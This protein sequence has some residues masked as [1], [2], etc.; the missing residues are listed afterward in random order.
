VGLL[1]P[2]VLRGRELSLVSRI[3]QPKEASGEVRP[4]ER[5]GLHGGGATT[6][7]AWQRPKPAWKAEP[8]WQPRVDTV[9]IELGARR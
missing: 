8:G 1:Q 6:E 3:D 9:R 5:P 2:K 4:I 7:A